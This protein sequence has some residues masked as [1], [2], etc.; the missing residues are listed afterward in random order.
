MKIKNG[1]LERFINKIGSQTD[2]TAFQG[3]SFEMS[4]EEDICIHG[5]RDIAEYDDNKI[6]IKTDK[7]LIN[8][9]GEKLKVEKFSLNFTSIYGNINGIEFSEIR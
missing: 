9:I 8:V 2:L 4:G 6:I 5:C 3:F 7:F 1:T